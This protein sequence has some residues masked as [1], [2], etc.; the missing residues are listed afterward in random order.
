MELHKSVVDEKTDERSGPITRPA[1]TKAMQVKKISRELN[2][3]YLLQYILADYMEVSWPH[4]LLI[5]VA[6]NS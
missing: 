1:F 6:R 5:R 3:K 2:R 4:F